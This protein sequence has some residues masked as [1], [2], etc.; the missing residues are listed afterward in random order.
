M[1]A[2]VEEKK[3]IHTSYNLFMPLYLISGFGFPLLSTFAGIIWLRFS[4]KKNSSENT[5]ISPFY[6]QLY[7][8]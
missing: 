7:T 2:I 3:F 8:Y 4:L 6:K 1:L 5:K